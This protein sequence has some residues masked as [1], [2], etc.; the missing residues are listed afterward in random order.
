ML[1]FGKMS[2]N[3]L[4]TS[5]LNYGHTPKSQITIRTY[6]DHQNTNPDPFT[7]NVDRSQ[8]KSF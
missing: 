3:K 1:V 6:R 7:Q 4:G 8:L 5:E 2:Q